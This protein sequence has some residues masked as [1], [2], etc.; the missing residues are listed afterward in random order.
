MLTASII[1]TASRKHK[2]KRR[3]TMMA[4]CTVCDTASHNIDGVQDGNAE[5]PGHRC[6]YRLCICSAGC[7]ERFPFSCEACTKPSCNDHRIQLF[8]MR[9]CTTCASAAWEQIPEP[10]CQCWQ[11]DVDQFSA[12]GCEIHNPSSEW[13]ELW[14]SMNTLSA[15]QCGVKE[16]ADDDVRTREAAI[17]IGV[18]PSTVG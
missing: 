6:A 13:N 3:K 8:G 2:K 14:R 9:L 1:K 7:V 10:D 5:R 17:G 18:L 15:V 16:A 4:T 11:T 12:Y